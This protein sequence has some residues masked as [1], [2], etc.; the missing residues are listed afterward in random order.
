MD[1]N[2]LLLL[3]AA[4]FLGDFAFQSRWM[5]E[6]KGKSWEVN[7]Y[8]TLT[9]TA[10][11]F[12][13]AVLAGLNLPTW[14]FVTIMISHFLIDPLKARYNI[15]KSIWADQL[16]HLVVIYALYLLI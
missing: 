5:V 6:N 1:I 9:Y 13:V 8:H 10:T 15:V 14:F 12:V 3:A 4:H 16:L 7:A 11:I 2:G